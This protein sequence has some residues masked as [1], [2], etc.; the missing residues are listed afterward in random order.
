MLCFHDSCDDAAIVAKAGVAVHPK[1]LEQLHA[2]VKRSINAAPVVPLPACYAH[3]RL[4]HSLV[5]GK[6][7]AFVP[8]QVRRARAR[9]RARPIATI[10]EDPSAAVPPGRFQTSAPVLAVPGLGCYI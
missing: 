8:S 10:A 9:R 1:N 6:R 4:S 2:L 7:V 3:A 5:G